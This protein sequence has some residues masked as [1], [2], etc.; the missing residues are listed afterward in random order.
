VD[1]LADKPA[2]SVIDVTLSWPAPSDGWA[3]RYAE[4][5]F[6]AFWLS[7][8]AV[9]WVLAAGQFANG[10]PHPAHPRVPPLLDFWL[11]VVWLGMWTLGGVIALWGLWSCFRPARPESVRL[12]AE[13]LRHDSDGRRCGWGHRAGPKPAQVARSDI[14]GFVLERVGGRQRLCLDRGTDRPEIGAGLREPDREWLFAV[15]QSWHTPNQPLQQTGGASR[16]YGV[17]R[18]SSPPAA[19]LSVSCRRP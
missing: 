12:G 17:Q 8:W 9:C 13:V 7:G 19:E 11:L 2:G 16:L 6:L 10:G 3:R 5:A 1:T 18:L 14:R 15:L 4:A